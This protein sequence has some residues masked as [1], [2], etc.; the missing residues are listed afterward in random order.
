MKK[1]KYKIN[2]L[3]MAGI[4]SYYL[5]ICL[6]IFEDLEM[7]KKSLFSLDIVCVTCKMFLVNWLTIV[8]LTMFLVNF[9]IK[10]FKTTQTERFL[11]ILVLKTCLRK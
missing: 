4:Q 10:V 7:G 2:K 11:W 6:F 1:I 5:Y 3:G 9:Y 8:W